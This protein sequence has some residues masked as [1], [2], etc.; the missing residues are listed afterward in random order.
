MK[1]FW[2]ALKLFGILAATVGALYAGFRYFDNM[3]DD[4]VDVK[5]DM[6]E[7]YEY[8]QQVI[9]RLDTALILIENVRVHQNN[10]DDMIRDMYQAGRFYL[11]NQ[12]RYTRDQLNQILQ[13]IMKDNTQYGDVEKSSVVD[14]FDMRVPMRE[15]DIQFVPLDTAPK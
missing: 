11:E 3:S 14:T 8:Q 1:G 7:Q 13:E 12:E 15:S 9:E 10:Q 6:G 2:N 4:I 5:E